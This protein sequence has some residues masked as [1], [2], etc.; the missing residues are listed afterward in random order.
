VRNTSAQRFTLPPWFFPSPAVDIRPRCQ[1]VLENLDFA[2]G[3]L[4]EE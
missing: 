1:A 4:S 2:A 3:L